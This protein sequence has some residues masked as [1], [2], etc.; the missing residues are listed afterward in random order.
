MRDV[1]EQLTRDIACDVKEL[2]SEILPVVRSM[3]GDVGRYRRERKRGLKAI[4]SEVYSAPR[5][6]AAVKLLPELKL[7]PG[8][9]LDLTTVDPDDGMPWDFDNPRNREKALRL[10]R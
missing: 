7:V 10:L 5:N 2:S 8:F 9:A 6:T 4:V 1:L 3:A